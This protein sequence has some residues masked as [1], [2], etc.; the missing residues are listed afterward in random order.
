MMGS[1]AERSEEATNA[2]TL[3]ED[4]LYSVVRVLKALTSLSLSRFV[5]KRYLIYLMSSY[6]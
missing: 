2:E 1:E 6:S 4:V 5:R 3:V